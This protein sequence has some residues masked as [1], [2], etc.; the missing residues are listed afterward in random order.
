MAVSYTHLDVYKRQV[1]RL[2]TTCSQNIYILECNR[3]KLT[4]VGQ[5]FYYFLFF[6]KISVII[7]HY[8][9]IRN[10]LYSQNFD[11][12]KKSARTPIRVHRTKMGDLFHFVQILG[13]FRK[14]VQ[15][16]QVFNLLNNKNRMQTKH[17]HP[18]FLS[19]YDVVWQLSADSVHSQFSGND[20]PFSQSTL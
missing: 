9:P 3:L 18:V 7:F 4:S 6:D 13:N 8:L 5:V 1:L 20:G 16:Y 11:N 15:F 2:K 17:L 10:I 14:H 12:C 19:L